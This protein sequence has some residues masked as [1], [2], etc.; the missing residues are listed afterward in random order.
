[1]NLLTKVWE[2][3]K[4]NTKV[5]TPTLRTL[6]TLM[7]TVIMSWRAGIW[8]T[9]CTTKGS[10]LRSFTCE[11]GWCTLLSPAEFREV[12]SF[13]TIV[14][15]RVPAGA[16]LRRRMLLRATVLAGFPLLLLWLWWCRL[17]TQTLSRHRLLL[18]LTGFPV[19]SGVDLFRRGLL[20]AWA[21]SAA[22]AVCATLASTHVIFSQYLTL[23]WL[24]EQTDAQSLVKVST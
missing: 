16:L 24:A 5:N 20:L 15:L 1:M 18:L 22:V 10:K 14:A 7:L 13:P 9:F 8:F 3:I 2:Y 11:R 17:I 12:S 19:T 6:L 21:V 4:S 23:N